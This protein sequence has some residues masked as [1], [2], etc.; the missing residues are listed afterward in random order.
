MDIGAQNLSWKVAHSL[1]DSNLRRDLN[2]VPLVHITNFR[3]LGL[4][5]L[6]K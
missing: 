6:W 4:G 2:V 3:N 5:P 1:Y